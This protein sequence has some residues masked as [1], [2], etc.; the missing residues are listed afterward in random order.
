MSSEDPDELL[1]QAQERSA[2]LE[3]YAA[4]L[5]RTYAEVRRHSQHL[6]ALHQVNTRIASAL[7]PQEVLASA[8][9]ALDDLLNYHTAS[10]YLVDLDVAVPAEGPHTVTPSE[11]TLPRLRARRSLDEHDAA[12][13]DG[14]VADESSPLMEAI[15]DQQ[16]VGRMSPAGFLELAVPLVAGGRA[17]GGFEVTL[18]APLGVDDVKILELLAAAAAVALHNAHLYQEV[19]RLATTDPLTG[20]SNYRHFHELLNLEV[21]RARRMRYSVGM[22]MM[23]LDHFKLVNDRHGHPAGDR[24]L[25]QV[26]E[27]LRTRL[28]RTDVVA[29]VGGEEFAAVLPGDGIDE[30]TIV[31]EKLRSCV[32]ALAPISGGMTAESTQVTLSLGATSLAPDTLDAQLLIGCADRALYEAKRNGRNQV[33]VWRAT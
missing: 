16:S 19:Q 9:D 23:D 24:A 33:Q 26:A 2:Q 27:L 7:D 18:A 13:D 14:A 30:V 5:S 29:R 4:D 21:Q 32:A 3:A 1:R 15:R 12:P 17:L 28:R 22:L 31:A 8:L 11:G 6:T 20:L 25:K 10:I